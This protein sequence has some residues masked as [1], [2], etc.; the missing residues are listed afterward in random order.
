MRP[1][2]KMEERK[3]RR[4]GQRDEGGREGRRKSTTGDDQTRGCVNLVSAS[5]FP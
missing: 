2:P 4:E 3:R 5:A 1:C